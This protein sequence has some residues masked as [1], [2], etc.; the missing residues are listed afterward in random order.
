MNLM[1]LHLKCSGKSGVYPYSEWQLKM[2]GVY[3]FPWDIS[4]GAFARYQQ[5]YPYVLFATIR[6]TSLAPSLGTTSHL[7]MVEPFGSRRF[8]NIFSWISNLKKELIS[9]TTDV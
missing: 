4:A 5:G 9:A 6:D 1:R 2:S 3:Q 8:D 7:I